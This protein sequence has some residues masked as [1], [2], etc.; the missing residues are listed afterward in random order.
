[1][2]KNIYPSLL[3]PSS[4]LDITVFPEPVR[5]FITTV[6]RS[7]GC[8]LSF[9]TLGALAAMATAA[10]GATLEYQP[11]HRES[12]NLFL[13]VVGRTGSAKSPMIKAC[14]RPF[15]YKLMR[16]Y[17]D[18][19]KQLI[20]WKKNRYIA[21]QKNSKKVVLAQKPLKPEQH[22]ITEGTIKGI[23]K[24][25]D[26][27]R[28]LGVPRHI[29]LY[30]D[31]LNRLFRDIM[32]YRICKG[33]DMEIDL[34]LA[35]KYISVYDDMTII[36]TLL[37]DVFRRAITKDNE[38]FSRFLFAFCDDFP[39]CSNFDFNVPLAVREA[40][41]AYVMN[42]MYWLRAKLKTQLPGQATYILTEKQQARIDEIYDE[43]HKR[44]WMENNTAFKKW[45]INLHKIAI[46][47]AVMHREAEL[48]DTSL[49]LAISLI[50]YFVGNLLHFR[51]KAP[52]L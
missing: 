11:S 17:E 22:I 5:D 36:G 10:A 45:E 32:A 28:R 37:P 7:T 6:S 30:R 41:D 35:G 34:Q 16:D 31:D 46:I 51:H 48:S 3:G 39:P 24:T 47:M 19:E 23:Q 40:Y 27:H 13:G 52:T 12:P 1:M 4:E 29:L 50:R 38:L 25:F 20:D 2:N 8:P 26:L 49:E 21:A 15:L 43:L 44:G 9:T 18:Y 42:T 14:L 33:S